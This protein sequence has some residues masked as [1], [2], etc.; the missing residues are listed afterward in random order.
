MKAKLYFTIAILFCITAIFICISLG[1]VYISPKELFSYPQL[2][3]YTKTVLMDLRLPRVIMAFLVGMLLASSGN[4]VQIIFQNPLADPYIIGIASSA[5][6]GAVVAYLLG[7]PEY[8][9]GAVA[10][11]CCLI[12]TLFLF[13][14]AK[15]GN[16]IHISTLLIMGITLASFLAGFTSFSIY[17]IGED[18]F[19]ITIWLMGY[20]G[21]ASW[22]QILFLLFPII[23][24]TLYF[25]QKRNALDILLLG[26][27]QAHSMGIQVSKLKSHCLILASLMVAFSVAFTGMIGFVGLIVP[28]IV[29]NIVG[30]LNRK[31]IP[32]TLFFGGTFLLVCDTLGRMILAP[33]EIP[34]GVITSLLGAP[35]FF[36]LAMKNR[37]NML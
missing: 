20:L 19:K 17:W 4:V 36:Y 12:S 27:E 3:D 29:R 32:C 25:Y 9:Y 33:L 35:F 24:S 2:D 5:T 11:V 31:V 7:L 37:R 16:H 18:S 28:H 13:R 1:N 21:N 8:S 15:K 26:D 34:I 14:I 23:F 6:F 10:F 30:P 22:K